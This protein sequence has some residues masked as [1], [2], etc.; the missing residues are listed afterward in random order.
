MTERDDTSNA[1][2][3][4][5]ASNNSTPCIRQ[6]KAEFITIRVSHDLKEKLVASARQIDRPLSWAVN[7]ILEQKMANKQSE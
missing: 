4:P 1:G 3:A 7:N 6:K 5:P 2:K